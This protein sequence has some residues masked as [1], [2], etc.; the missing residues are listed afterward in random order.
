MKRKEVR[1]LFTGSVFLCGGYKN[2]NHIKNYTKMRTKYVIQV[3]VVQLCWVSVS[4]LFRV[5]GGMPV[6]YNKVSCLM[7]NFLPFFITWYKDFEDNI[8]F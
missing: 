3:L 8:Y 5:L 2:S 7:P 4:L 1:K 6:F